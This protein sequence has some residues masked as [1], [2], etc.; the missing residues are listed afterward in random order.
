MHWV[1]FSLLS[2]CSH[3]YLAANAFLLHGTSTS[4]SHPVTTLRRGGEEGGFVAL[5]SSSSPSPVEEVEKMEGPTFLEALF[6]IAINQS[7]WEYMLRMKEKGYDGVVPVKLGI[8]G[9][10]NFLL[11]PEAVR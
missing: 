5:N 9:D 11:S 8:L 1:L 7:P 6:G 4:T 3:D 10:Y 2:L